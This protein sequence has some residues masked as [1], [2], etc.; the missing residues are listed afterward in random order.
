MALQKLHIDKILETTLPKAIL[1]FLR[2]HLVL[3]Q[4]AFASKFTHHYFVQYIYPYG[5]VKSVEIGLLLPELN[6]EEYTLPDSTHFSGYE[7]EAMRVADNATRDE[8]DLSSY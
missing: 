7:P 2:L 3:C 8:A 4:G 1:C 6:L 5:Y